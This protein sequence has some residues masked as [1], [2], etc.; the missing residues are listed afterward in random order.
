[1]LDILLQSNKNMLEED[2]RSGQRLGTFSI[3]AGFSA[4]SEVLMAVNCEGVSKTNRRRDT[5]GSTLP[6]EAMHISE[7]WFFLM[8]EHTKNLSSPLIISG[9]RG[10]AAE[11]D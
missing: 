10:Y 9:N 5:A 8:N 7:T 2:R 4:N 6:V 3:I 11:N 1:M